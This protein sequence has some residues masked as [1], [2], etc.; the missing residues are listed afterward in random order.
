MN[1]LKTSFK[2]YRCLINWYFSSLTTPNTQKLERAMANPSEREID[3]AV[4]YVINNVVYFIDFLPNKNSEYLKDKVLLEV[5]PGQDFGISLVL[6][7][8]GL[9]KMLLIDKFFCKWDENFHPVYYRTLLK[10]VEH[11]YPEIDFSDLKNV[12][13]CND[14]VSERFELLATGLE[15]IPD[16]P[17]ESVDITFSNAC[18][19]HLTDTEAAIKELGRITKP[20]GIGFHQID[21]R[22]HRNFDEPLEFLTMPDII[23]NRVFALS[24]GYLGN[25]LR[26]NDFAHYFKTSGFEHRFSADM[27]AEESYLD[28]IL[29]CANSKFKMIPIDNIRI[30]S[31]R[32]FLNKT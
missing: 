2:D 20:G 32:F 1:Y 13:N 10:K 31:G 3:D 4:N 7:G 25:R 22:D 16:I 29:K 14:H 12:I 15:N 9:K 8:F 27:F 30:L 24:K 5:G 21:F 11:Y 19:E 6:M 26:Y 28:E 23:F 17:D 18:F